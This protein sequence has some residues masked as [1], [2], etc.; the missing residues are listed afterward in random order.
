MISLL[1]EYLNILTLKHADAVDPKKIRNTF[2][3]KRAPNN[4][5][6]TNNKYS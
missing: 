3:L 4:L 6:Y 1:S 5:E 2:Y